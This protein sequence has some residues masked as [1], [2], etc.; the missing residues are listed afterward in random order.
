[1]YIG[2]DLLVRVTAIHDSSPLSP[3]TQPW[4]HPQDLSAVP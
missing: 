3:L 1:M 4:L 2:G